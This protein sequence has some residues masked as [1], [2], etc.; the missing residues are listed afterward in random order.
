M[1]TAITL[2]YTVPMVLTWVLTL[3]YWERRRNR[4]R[5]V[6]SK[7]GWW[8]KL[9]IALSLILSFMVIGNIVACIIY[10]IMLMDDMV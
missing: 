1:S 10:G 3:V 2:M 6:G 8:D 7:L 4:R 5:A 9:T